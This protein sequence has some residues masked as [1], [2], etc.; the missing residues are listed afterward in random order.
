M[1]EMPAALRNLF[2]GK[3]V[4]VAPHMDDELL[5]CGGTMALHPQKEL[6]HVIY[7]TDGMKSPA[8][9]LPQ[10]S[11]TADLG[12]LRVQES[13]AAMAH[14]GVPCENLHFLRLPEAE[15]SQHVDALRRGLLAQIDSLQPDFLLMPFRFDRHPDHLAINRVLTEAYEQGR[16]HTRLIEYFVYYR[17]R[18]LPGRDVRQ[19]IR[20]PYLLEVD[21][22]S[23]ATLKREALDAFQSQTTI[24][25]PW[26]TR[27][28]LTP[29]LLDDVSR[30]PE[31]FLAYDSSM[32][33]TS[34]FA[35][36]VLWIRFVHRV[37]PYLQKWKYLVGSSLQ[38]GIQK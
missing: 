31:Y 8:P 30:T 27:P 12:E 20:S 7:A 26:Q 19:Y 16:I 18:L 29:Q 36:A 35:K 22:R 5:A 33:G 25:Y 10:D 38:R 4:V 34:V 17:W 11:I 24:F 23:V 9:V 15:L 21:T 3:L 32:S 13:Q 2:P 1:S 6:V 37:E 28:I 14:L